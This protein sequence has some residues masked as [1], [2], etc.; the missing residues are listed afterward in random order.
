MGVRNL[1]LGRLLSALVL[2]F[3]VPATAHAHTQ[4][5]GVGD[6]LNG[7][8]HPL[9]TPSHLLILLG[10]G[11]LAGQRAPLNLKTPMMTF[12]PL[13]AIALLLTMTGAVKTVYPPVL[14]AIALIAG[15]LVAMEARPPRLAYIAL[16]AAAAVAIGLDSAVESGD[17]VAMLKRLFGTWVSLGLMVFNL[18]Y[19]VSLLAKQKWQKIGVR[20]VGS[21]LIAISFLV[22]AFLL[23]R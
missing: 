4:V 3:A 20:V 22:L 21:W 8:L 13:A 19:Y 17:T 9:T 23:R 12:L 14:I 1:R 7:L 18:A 16:F 2:F 15:I 10:L 11:L 6:V 5:E